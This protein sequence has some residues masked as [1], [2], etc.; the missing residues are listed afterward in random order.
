MVFFLVRCNLT[1]FLLGIRL[2]DGLILMLVAVGADHLFRIDLH[3]YFIPIMQEPLAS[4]THQQP[5]KLIGK[6]GL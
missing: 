4:H 5:P 2:S 3:S 6:V 1:L